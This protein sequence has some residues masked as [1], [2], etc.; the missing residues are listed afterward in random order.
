[1][2]GD[3][4]DGVECDAVLANLPYIADDELLPPEVALL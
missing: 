4:L 1:M 2:Q 3:L